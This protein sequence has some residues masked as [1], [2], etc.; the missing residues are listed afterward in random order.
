M[1]PTLPLVLHT[2]LCSFVDLQN[3]KALQFCRIC[4]FAKNKVSPTFYLVQVSLEKSMQDQQRKI[5]LQYRTILFS[6]EESFS[7]CHYFRVGQFRLACHM[8]R[9]VQRI[10]FLHTRMSF[11]ISKTFKVLL[12]NLFFVCIYLLS[13]AFTSGQVSLGLPATRTTLLE[14]HFLHQRN[15]FLHQRNQKFYK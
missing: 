8:I 10:V 3:Y 11:S 9:Q 14:N 5:F 4:C 1:A 7:I 12:R 15:I 13:S 2:Y 6:R